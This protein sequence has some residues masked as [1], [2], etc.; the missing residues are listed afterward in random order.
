MS[1]PFASCI[2]RSSLAPVESSELCQF[3]LAVADVMSLSGFLIKLH[4]TISPPAEEPCI[5]VRSLR[6]TSL[7]WRGAVATSVPTVVPPVD[8]ISSS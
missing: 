1:W 6:P 2:A 7:E 5:I 3:V 8:S 4:L